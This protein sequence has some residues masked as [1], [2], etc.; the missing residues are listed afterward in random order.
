MIKDLQY[1]IYLNLVLKFTLTIVVISDIVLII[2]G[3]RGVG[4]NEVLGNFIV[5]NKFTLTYTHMLMLGLLY[6]VIQKK[7][8]FRRVIF[9]IATVFC[10]LIAIIADCTTGIIGILVVWFIVIIN[11]TKSSLAPI[12]ESH[13]V[14]IFTMIIS[15]SLIVGSDIL[16]ENPAIKELFMKYSHTSKILSGRIDMYNICLQYIPKRKWVGYGI[17]CTI[18]EELLTWGNP[19]NGLLKMLLDHGIIGT[20]L[21]FGIIIKSFNPK[22]KK[23]KIKHELILPFYAVLYALAICSVV[24]LSINAI[25][26]FSLSL[27]F[28]LNNYEVN[29]YDK[30]VK[31]KT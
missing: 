30:S 11:F 16:L 29:Q 21:F 31:E 12:I 10:I 25:F 3:G 17:N 4:G 20:L 9:S 23:N 7:R 6:F 14:F 1:K 2:T 5:G 26:Y 24:E 15:T 28:A 8:N 18:V 27:I 22:Y 13:W 19:Q